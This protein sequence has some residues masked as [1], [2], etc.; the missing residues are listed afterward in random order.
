MEIRVFHTHLC[1]IHFFCV[2]L[3]CEIN[4][5]KDEETMYYRTFCDFG[6]GLHQHPERFEI[7]VV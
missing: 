1:A 7:Y 2:S 5:Y 3:Q 4:A 6:H